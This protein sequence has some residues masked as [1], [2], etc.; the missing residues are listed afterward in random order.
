ME[1][2][3]ICTVKFYNRWKG[4]MLLKECSEEFEKSRVNCYVA[5]GL[6]IFSA[7]R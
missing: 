5:N 2:S 1:K 3:V 4:A 6:F 7:S